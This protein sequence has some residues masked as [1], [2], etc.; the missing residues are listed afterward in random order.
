MIPAIKFGKSQSESFPEVGHSRA[1][2][3]THTAPPHIL[4]P[5]VVVT[6]KR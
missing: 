6:G 3:V 4:R 1:L 2:Q 5:T